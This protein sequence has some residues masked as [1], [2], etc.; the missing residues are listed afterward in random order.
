M[1][2]QNIRGP[3]NKLLLLDLVLKHIPSGTTSGVALGL[4]D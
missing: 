2:A 1:H 3:T 4:V